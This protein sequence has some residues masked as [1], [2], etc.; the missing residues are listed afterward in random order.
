MSLHATYEV[1]LL[2]LLLIIIIIIFFICPVLLGFA[3]FGIKLPK[4]LFTNE[5]GSFLEQICPEIEF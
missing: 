4:F 5:P 1:F 3:F 2:L